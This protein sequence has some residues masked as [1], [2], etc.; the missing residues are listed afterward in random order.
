[1]NYNKSKCHVL[2]IRNNNPKYIY[3]LNGHILNP[4]NEEKDLGVLIR[5]DLSPKSQIKACVSKANKMLGM[6]KHTFSY[7]DKEIFL[8]LYKTFVRPILEYGQEIWSPFHKEDIKEIE[9]VQRRATKL[10]P[11]LK[12]LSY[13]DRLKHLDLFKLEDRRHRG[14]LISTF[15]IINGI[16]DIDKDSLFKPKPQHH[17]SR[18]NDS[19][20]Q[21][22]KSN[23]DIRKN[24]FTQRI[25]V[26]WNSL[27]NFVVKSSDVKS[28]KR[29]YDT[30][31]RSKSN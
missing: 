29:N 8:K 10:V 16:M 7:L 23:T 15:K 21:G 19:K 6:I 24:T 12:D 31:I 20:L 1:M 11:H 5:P 26:P 4:T 9:S 18:T 3:H 14:D 22:E 27:P 17:E 30:H 2:H 25:I 28:F 13:E